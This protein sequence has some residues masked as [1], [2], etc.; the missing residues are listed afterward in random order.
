MN[1]RDDDNDYL[2]KIQPTKFLINS[3]STE[4]N[5]HGRRKDANGI[6]ESFKL[7]NDWQCV[8]NSTWEKTKNWIRRY[9]QLNI[10]CWARLS[11]FYKGCL[12]YS[13]HGCLINKS[14]LRCKSTGFILHDYI[15]SFHPLQHKAWACVTYSL[16]LPRKATTN[17]QTINRNV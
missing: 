6:W 7:Y 1:I 13:S 5:K 4:M 16:Y 2:N 10:L 17:Q 9:I 15:F 12:T 11:M 14:A 3:S 8:V